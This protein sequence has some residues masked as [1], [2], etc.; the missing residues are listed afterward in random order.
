MTSEWSTAP[1]P[2][3]EMKFEIFLFQPRVD[4]CTP[5]LVLAEDILLTEYE[6]TQGKPA[7][8]IQLDGLVS[9]GDCPFYLSLLEGNSVANPDVFALE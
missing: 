6:Y 7:L 2:Y 5:Q 1:V 3:Q 8:I 4:E 9:N